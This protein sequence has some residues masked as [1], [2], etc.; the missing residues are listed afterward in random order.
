MM[1]K[2]KSVGH[3][4]DLDF[5]KNNVFVITNIKRGNRLNEILETY[6]HGANDFYVVQSA[7]QK[8]KAVI[9]NLDFF[10]ELRTIECY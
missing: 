7:Q 9:A 2:E 5:I 6:E 4:V 8:G 3:S 10:R 1:D